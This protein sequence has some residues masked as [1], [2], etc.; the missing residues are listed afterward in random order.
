VLYLIVCGS[1]LAHRV[2]TLVKA[3]QADGWEVCVV[4]TPDGRKFVDAGAL[5]RQTG[6]PVRSFYKNPGDPD[7]LPDPDAMIVAP[8][9]VNT[10]NKMAAG[11]ADTWPSAW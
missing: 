7:M 11:I 8:A 4:C 10:V 2:G 1:P 6:H 5:S 3:A 9:T